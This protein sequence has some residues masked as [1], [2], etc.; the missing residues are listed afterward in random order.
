[1]SKIIV[2]QNVVRNIKELNTRSL[3]N[4]KNALV[5]LEVKSKGTRFENLVKYWKTL[6]MD[7]KDVAVDIVKE[8]RER[9]LK[10]VSI[11]TILSSVFYCAKHNPSLISYRENIISAKNKLLLVHPTT[12]NVNT[13]LHLKRVENYFN[14]G[15]IRRLNLGIVSLIWADYYSDSCSSSQAK[16]K[17]LQ[18]K[19]S[20]MKDHVIDVG[21]LDY[22]WFLSDIMENYDLNY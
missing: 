18:M 22:W 5:R 16:C 7:Y 13:A 17:Y 4:T 2:L 9:P 14:R 8:S 10:T 15:C 1:M 19:Y 12:Q 11:L 20:D 3:E 21:F 6:Y